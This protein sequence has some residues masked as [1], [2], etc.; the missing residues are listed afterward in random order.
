MDQDE[1]MHARVDNQIDWYDKK[2]QWN[3]RWFRRLRAIEL[4]VAAS[5][6]LLAGYISAERPSIQLIVGLLGLVVASIAG[7]TGLYSFQENW[8]EYRTT[9]ESLCHEKHLFLTETQPYD[10]EAPFPLFVKRVESLISAENTRWSQFTRS[11]TR[12]KHNG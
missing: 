6:P 2:S 1:Y 5:I 10:G 8:V 11:D 9:C 12:G 4:V 7:V 3:Q